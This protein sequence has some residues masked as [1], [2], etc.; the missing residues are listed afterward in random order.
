[1]SVIIHFYLPLLVDAMK[2][3]T[4]LGFGNFGDVRCPCR[5]SCIISSAFIVARIKQA[6]VYGYL[7]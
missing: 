6:G 1:M 7:G 5:T 3:F 4:S 2:I